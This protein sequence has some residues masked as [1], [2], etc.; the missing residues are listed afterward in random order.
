MWKDLALVRGNDAKILNKRID[1]YAKIFTIFYL[2]C[3]RDCVYMQLAFLF[4]HVE[5][6]VPWKELRMRDS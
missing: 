6:P 5:P 3:K 4:L 1:I 2:S